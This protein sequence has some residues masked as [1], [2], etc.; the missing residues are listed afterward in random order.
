MGGVDLPSRAIRE[1]IAASINLVVQQTRYADGGRRISAVSEVAGIGDDGQIE[2]RPIFE[3][4]RTGTGAG[5]AVLGEH[6][7]TGYLPSFLDA[8]IVGGLIRAGEPYL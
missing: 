6:R 8:F 5:G 2:L 1:Q 3:F 7:P 4:V